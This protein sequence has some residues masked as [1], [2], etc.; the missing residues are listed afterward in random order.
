MCKPNQ[1]DITFVSL[2]SRDG[3][4]S[5]HQIDINCTMSIC[6]NSSRQY[7][8]KILTRIVKVSIYF[9][10]KY[11]I[12]T[13]VTLLRCFNYSKSKMLL[14]YYW[15][16]FTHKVNIQNSFHGI[17]KTGVAMETVS[18]VFKDINIRDNLVHINFTAAVSSKSIYKSQIL[19]TH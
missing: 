9:T 5:C 4:C 10:R 12:L 1:A 13:S 18:I 16:F 7:I 19:L 8:I 11:Q 6:N 3:K 17:L 14:L 15:I 2:K